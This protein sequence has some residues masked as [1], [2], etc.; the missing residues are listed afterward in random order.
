MV[1]K[2]QIRGA[3]VFSEILQ[4]LLAFIAFAGLVF[5]SG[6]WSHMTNFVFLEEMRGGGKNGFVPVFKHLMCLCCYVDST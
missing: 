5:T 2:K 1:I 4:V 3:K 6:T